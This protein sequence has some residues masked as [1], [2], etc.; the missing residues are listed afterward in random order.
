MRNPDVRFCVFIMTSSL[1]PFDCFNSII[2]S[3]W[4]VAQS[5]IAALVAF[6]GRACWLT[7]VSRLTRAKRALRLDTHENA[8]KEQTGFRICKLSI[9]M[10]GYVRRIE[11]AASRVL[12]W[13]S[14]CS[15]PWNF[16]SAWEFHYL[17]GSADLRNSVR[18]CINSHVL[19]PTC[20]SGRGETALVG[21][22]RREPRM[23]SRETVPWKSFAFLARKSDINIPI[24]RKE[25]TVF[26]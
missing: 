5:E 16:Y 24:G 19:S 26:C 17:F 22:E 6:G 20:F 18:R 1:S 9:S 23:T 2:C 14:S 4:S 11:R 25:K 7:L 12:A 10:S 13:H 3:V 8:L 21:Y 15:P